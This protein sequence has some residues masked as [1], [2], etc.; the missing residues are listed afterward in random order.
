MGLDNQAL[1]PDTSLLNHMIPE[2]S[3]LLIQSDVCYTS[4]QNDFEESLTK[5]RL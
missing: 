1:A 2:A 3:L 4:D 5:S